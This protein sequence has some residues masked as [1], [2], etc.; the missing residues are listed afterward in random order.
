[1][2]NV[3]KQHLDSHTAILWLLQWKKTDHRWFGDMPFYMMLVVVR[4]TYNDE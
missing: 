1:M 3:W 4:G 2:G